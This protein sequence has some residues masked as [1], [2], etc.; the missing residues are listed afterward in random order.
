M[1]NKITEDDI[2]DTLAEQWFRKNIHGCWNCGGWYIKLAYYEGYK[3]ALAGVKPPEKKPELEKVCD[4]FE[5]WIEG[6]T[7]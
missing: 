4:E 3:A 2:W 1:T 7:K 5:A 6:E